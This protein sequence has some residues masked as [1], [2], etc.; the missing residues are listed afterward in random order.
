MNRFLDFLAGLGGLVERIIVWI[1]RE[2]LGITGGMIRTG[3]RNARCWVTNNPGKVLLGIGASSILWAPE[4][5]AMLLPVFLM[6]AA[7]MIL[8][9]NFFP[10]KKK[11]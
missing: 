9:Q 4:F 11:K 1:F 5:A 2:I 3:Y 10:K 7:F 6:G 8:F